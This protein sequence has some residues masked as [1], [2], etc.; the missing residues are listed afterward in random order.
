MYSKGLIPIV[1]AFITVVLLAGGTIYLVVLPEQ[2]VP[3]IELPMVD[4]ERAVSPRAE[5]TGE[6]TTQ[7]ANEEGYYQYRGL[8]DK[9]THP[10]GPRLCYSLGVD[11]RIPV[12]IERSASPAQAL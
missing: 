9:T 4:K 6:K 11:A 5:T 2:S 12:S 7:T 10:D 8:L 1:I 3:E